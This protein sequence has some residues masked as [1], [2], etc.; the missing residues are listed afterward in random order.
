MNWLPG[1]GTGARESAGLVGVA[2]EQAA[3]GLG[4]SGARR[5]GCDAGVEDLAG[6]D[7]DEEQHVVAA[8]QVGVD[9]EEVAGQRCLRV[10]E[11]RPGDRRA[12]RG[13]VD[14]AGFE[15][16]PDGG[17]SGPVAEADSSPWI[18]R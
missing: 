11:L 12:F 8:Q 6:G 13:R 9:G 14:T 18:R 10:K 7:V 5:V 17:W 15:N 1:S 16:L 2:D 4:G 3:G